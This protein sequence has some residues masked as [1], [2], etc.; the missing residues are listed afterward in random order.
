MAVRETQISEVVDIS[1]SGKVR[2]TQLSEMVNIKSTSFVRETQLSMMVS[3]P[4]VKVSK[5]QPN[6]FVVT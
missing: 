2:E 1:P 3:V 4:A 6:V 5:G